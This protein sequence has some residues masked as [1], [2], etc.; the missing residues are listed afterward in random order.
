MII[1]TKRMKQ[2]QEGE[3]D[4]RS[5]RKVGRNIGKGKAREEGIEKECKKVQTRGMNM[6]GG[7]QR[8]KWREEE[9]RGRKG[10]RVKS[11]VEI[12][13]I[14][15]NMKEREGEEER[16]K[17]GAG[18]TLKGVRVKILFNF[19]ATYNYTWDYRDVGAVYRTE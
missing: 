1:E 19:I 10:G 12:E 7:K 15:R 11:E 16:V 18:M 6:S 2:E 4:D 14:R 3:E 9:R 13:E 17:G 5:G 8:Y